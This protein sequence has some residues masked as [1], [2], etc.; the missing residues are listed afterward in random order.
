[1]VPDPGVLISAAI[2]EKGA[3]W[4]VLRRWMAGEFDLVVSP[5]LLHELQSVLARGKFRRYLTYE[6][7]SEYVSW[8]HHEAEVVRDPAESVVRGAVEADPDDE[9]LVGLAGTLGGGD[10]YLLSV[11]RHLLDLPDRAVKDGEGRNLARILTPGEFL[12]E[13]EQESHSR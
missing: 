3:P 5:R 11:D 9:Y 10:S 13:I 7:A 12:R 4:E 1:V 6:D 2:S 8:L